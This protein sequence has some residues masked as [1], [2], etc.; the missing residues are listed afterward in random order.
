[1]A[2]PEEFIDPSGEG[3]RIEKCAQPMPRA[4][5]DGVPEPVERFRVDRNQRL[6]VRTVARRDGTLCDSSIP[7]GDID[8]VA[9]QAAAFDHALLRSKTP[10]EIAGYRSKIRLVDLFSGCGGITLGVTE[11][12]RA[13]GMKAK[14]LLAVDIDET[15]LQVYKRNIPVKE[16][17]SESVSALLDG[18]PGE[19]L[20]EGEERLRERLKRVDILVGG[21]PCQGHSDLNNRTRRQ[22]PKNA[23]YLKMAR[24]AEVCSPTHIII[25]NVLGV[26]YDRENVFERTKQHLERL[27]YH[28]D[29]GILRGN[30]IGVPQARPRVVLVASR[31]VRVTIREVIDRYRVN[32]TRSFMWACGDL[33]GI[34][35]DSPFDRP[36]SPNPITQARIDYLFETD[37]GIYELPNHMRPPC[38]QHEHTYP[39][40][41][42]RIRPNDPAPTITTGFM[43][44]GQGRFVHP[45]QR[46]T[47][48]P[49]EGARIQCFPDWFEFGDLSRKAYLTLIGNAVPSKLAYVVALELLR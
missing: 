22:D 11:A 18:D 28:V 37:D 31:T 29:A 47:L 5:G 16:V 12:C 44:M 30:V 2:T 13:I 26:R 39:S 49:H 17:S 41:Y 21:P 36:S 4:Q 6:I 42:G 8:I 48:T 14:P 35:S 45:L 38:H 20:S 23:L 1:L 43:T 27:N 7:I 15:A 19:S 24:F 33:A 9:D 34:Q 32:T 40:V 3:F 46:R 25:E 10:P